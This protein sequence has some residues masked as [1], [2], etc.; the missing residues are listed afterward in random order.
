MSD[1]GQAT[2]CAVD[3]YVC[4]SLLKPH[5]RSKLK[6]GT[7]HP[8]Q[9]FE[10]ESGHRSCGNI[11]LGIVAGHVAMWPCENCDVFGRRYIEMLVAIARI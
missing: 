6:A 7:K 4:E 9:N 2:A 10:V 3:G 8:V 11:P 1:G 5:L